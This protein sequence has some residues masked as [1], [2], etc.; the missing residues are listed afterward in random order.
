MTKEWQ[1]KFTDD[2]LNL[3]L[4]G[5][6]DTLIRIGNQ[7]LSNESLTYIDQVRLLKKKIERIL[8]DRNIR[9]KRKK[10]TYV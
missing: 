3:L 7:E 9:R 1:K 2:E 10:V 8:K 5:V 6:S 4:D